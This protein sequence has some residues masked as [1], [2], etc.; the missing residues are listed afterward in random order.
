M[1][2]KEENSF[3]ILG[4]NADEEALDPYEAFAKYY[5]VWYQDFQD[6]GNFTS[7]GSADRRTGAGMHERHGKSAHTLCPGWLRDSRCGP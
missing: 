6:D 4:T 7:T 1:L 2:Q 3:E 5:D